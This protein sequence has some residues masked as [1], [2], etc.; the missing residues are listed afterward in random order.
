MARPSDLAL[1]RRR[2]R[3]HGT[4]QAGFRLRSRFLALAGAR[5]R[6]LPRCWRDDVA[7]SGKRGARPSLP[8]KSQFGSP[9][10]SAP[11]VACA[12]PGRGSACRGPS[13]GACRVGDPPP[14]LALA[15]LSPRCSPR[16]QRCRRTCTLPGDGPSA[17][18]WREHD[19]HDHHRDD[20]HARHR[21]PAHRPDQAGHPQE[22]SDF[23]RSDGFGA[24]SA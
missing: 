5:R 1:L 23:W 10:P 12:G 7:L 21:L 8:S 14:D 4:P 17:S 18:N 22:P 11:Q 19:D 24:I 9:H 13:P 15:P 20:R 6:R 3:L 2:C 16:R